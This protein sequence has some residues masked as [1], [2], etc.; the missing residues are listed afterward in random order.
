MLLNAVTTSLPH[1][2]LKLPL[3]KITSKQSTSLPSS[4]REPC[5]AWHGTELT[6]PSFWKHLLFSASI[7]SHFPGF[8][9]ASLAVPFQFLYRFFFFSGTFRYWRGSWLKLGLLGICPFFSWR[10]LSSLIAWTTTYADDY[11]MF[12]SLPE[13]FLS[14]K[15]V[16]NCLF[17][18]FTWRLDI[19]N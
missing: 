17:D 9:P 1:D 16:C 3:V 14:S 7:T 11:A 13:H 15:H 18:I 6:T 5:S 8:S 2:S 19:S 4:S 12:I 10:T